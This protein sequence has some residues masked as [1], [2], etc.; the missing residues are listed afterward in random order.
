MFLN[1]THF[2]GESLALSIIIQSIRVY[3][4]L[5]LFTLSFITPVF[6]LRA[7]YIIIIIRIRMKKSRAVFWLEMTRQLGRERGQ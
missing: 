2:S 6:S 3:I 7:D 1:V 4:R 5:T